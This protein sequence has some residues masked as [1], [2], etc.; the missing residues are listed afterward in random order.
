MMRQWTKL[1]PLVKL[2]VG[3]AILKPHNETQKAH[4]A[5]QT[6]QFNLA[7]GDNGAHKIQSAKI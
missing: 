5:F 1:I 7:Q 2:V 3:H 4:E 6:A